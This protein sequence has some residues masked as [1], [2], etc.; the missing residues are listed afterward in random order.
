MGRR[1]AT[2]RS[3]PSPVPVPDPSP[4][5]SDQP[6]DVSHQGSAARVRRLPLLVAKLPTLVIRPRV[7]RTTDQGDQRYATPQRGHERLAT[8]DPPRGA[9]YLRARV[10]HGLSATF[11]CVLLCPTG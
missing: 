6:F 10:V 4:S 9:T 3:P 7:F 2:S 5:S 1:I 8:S 11:E